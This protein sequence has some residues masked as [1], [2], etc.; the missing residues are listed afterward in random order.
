[1]RLR[2]IFL[3]SHRGP[4]CYYFRQGAEYV[5][6]ENTR[7]YLHARTILGC[8]MVRNL[9]LRFKKIKFSP[10]RTPPLLSLATTTPRRKFDALHHPL[11]EQQSPSHPLPRSPTN[12]TH[13]KNIYLSITIR[14]NRVRAFACYEYNMLVTWYNLS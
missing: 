5:L 14:G 6:E 2:N 8:R 10:P 11:T 13:Q 4:C 7:R 9:T 1:M 3:M 12:S